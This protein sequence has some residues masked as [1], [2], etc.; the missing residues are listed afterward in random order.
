MKILLLTQ[1]LPYPPDSGPKVKTW[2]TIKYLARDPRHEITLISFVRGDQTSELEHLKKYCARVLA[3]PIK[4][5][6]F[7]EGKAFLLSFITRRPWM[8]LRDDRKD[9]R[10]LIEQE[11]GAGQFDI[12][13]ADQTNMGQ[14][15]LSIPGGK[16]VLDTHN[17][18]WVLYKRLSETTQSRLM[19]WLLRRDWKLLKNYEG[20]LCSQFDAVIAVSQEDRRALLEANQHKSEI[21]VIPIAA[22]MEESPMIDRKPGAQ[23]IIHIGTMYWPPN[24][25]GMMWFIH[26]IFPQIRAVNSGIILDVIGARPPRELLAL[27]SLE[28]G[29]NVAGYIED[30]TPFLEN[31]AVMVVPLR[32]GGGMRVKILNALAQGIPIVTTTIG[33]EGIDVENGKHL[34]IAD[35][36]SEFAQAVIRLIENK[37]LAEDIS[38]NGRKLIAEKYDYRISLSRLESIYHPSLLKEYQEHT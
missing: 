8:I 18:L 31:A 5:S 9:M 34:L 20:W 10:D 2:H 24:I 1:V 14:F 21:H 23:H 27:S 37:D 12:I 13:H 35:T 32:S 15:A 33:C 30:T 22:D 36:P 11:A 4:R 6:L 7:L 17:A 29:V 19:C 38:L 25:D 3:V 26:D 16:K 28:D